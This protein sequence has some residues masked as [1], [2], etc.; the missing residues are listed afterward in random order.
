MTQPAIIVDNISKSYR[1]GVIGRQTLQ[2][3][4]RYWW[5]K[6]CGRNPAEHMLTI[7]DVP[8][9]ASRMKAGGNIFMALSD[10]SFQVGRGEV[11]GLI[12]RNG[13]GKST[14]LKILSR[15][16]EPSSGEAVLEGRL[17]SLLEVGTGFHPE[18][19]GKENIYLNG[20]ILGMAKAEVDDNFD[21]IVKFSGIAKF[22]DTPVKRYSSGMYVRLAFAVAAF[23]ESEILLVDEVLAV[24][25]AVF[26]R[27]C[28]DKMKEIT[29]CGRTIIFVSHNLT[30]ITRLCNRTI[31]LEE[32]R[33]KTIG[34]SHEIVR[35]YLDAGHGV[36]AERKWQEGD[37]VPGNHIVRLESVRIVDGD[38]STQGVADIRSCI[39]IEMVFNVM[40][41]GHVLLPN[42]HF[43]N[44]E[45]VLLFCAVEQN[46]LW[47][48]S[49][50]E[51][52]TYSSTA[53]IPGNLLADGTVIVGVAVT[54]YKP[55][56]IHFYERYAVAFEIVDSLEGD[57]AMGNYCGRMPGV[58]R[59]KL[60]WDAKMLK[61]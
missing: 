25:D 51:E 47:Q 26:Q 40:E 30:A 2:D 9:E 41:P 53:W 24:G 15:I 21:E 8:K 28:L 4:I 56:K 44:S 3:E 49:P 35:Q 14:L 32:G 33:V 45:G 23:L 55:L 37:K 29:E 6:V 39:G 11:I 17:A 27:K 1:L 36:S 22:I 19:T 48:N 60:D 61:K 12:G 46:T 57:T 31:L 16:T 59:P 18:L 42:F 7:E 43:T 13:A 50:R 58:V 34:P 52:G 38:R 20:T 10:I 54:T 5:H